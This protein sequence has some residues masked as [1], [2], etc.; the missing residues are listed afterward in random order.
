M[1]FDD[2]KRFEILARLRDVLGSPVAEHVM[3][4]LPPMDWTDVARQ[5][6]TDER[7]A[8]LRAEMNAG[9]AVTNGRIDVL[10]S[11]VEALA[12]RIGGVDQRVDDLKENINVRLHSLEENINVRFEA[13]RSDIAARHDALM[14]NSDVRFAALTDKI[15]SSHRTTRM[16]IGGLFA[17]VCTLI[18]V[19]LVR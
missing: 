7:F 12:A 16:Y 11:E 18:S 1:P 3:E 9:F 14:S 19:V 15:E 10:R 8:S 4:Y 13:V 6:A 5:S 17:L 2:T